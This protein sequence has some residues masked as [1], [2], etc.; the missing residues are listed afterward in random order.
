M[1]YYFDKNQMEEYSFTDQIKAGIF[2]NLE[3]NFSEISLE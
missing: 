1:V 3:I 2:E